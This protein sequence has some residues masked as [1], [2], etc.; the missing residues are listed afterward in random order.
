ML[1]A[2]QHG[3]P[4]SNFSY[5]HNENPA[6]KMD[7]HGV[8]NDT[9]SKLKG[10]KFGYPSC[11]PA[12]DTGLLNVASSQVGTL[13]KPDGVPNANDCA[14]RQ[15]GCLHFHSH[16]APLDIRFNANATSAYIAFHGNW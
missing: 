13:F 15:L 11:V 6:E 16:T 2:E 4:P 14:S 7:Y 9:V 8:L 10:A 12:W 3:Q 1:G 5:V